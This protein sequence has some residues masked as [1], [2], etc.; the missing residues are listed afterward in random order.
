MPH[1]NIYCNKPTV[2]QRQTDLP[3]AFGPEIMR[4]RCFL[5]S[6]ISKGT[7]F[8][9][10]LASESLQQRCTAIVQSS[11][12]F[13][14]IGG[15]QTIGLY[16]EITFARIKSIS[17]KIR[18]TEGISGID[19]RKT[20]ENSV[21]MRIIS[22]LSSPSEFADAVVCLYHLRWFDKYGFSACRFIVDDTL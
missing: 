11:N 12:L 18:T 9:P 10:C 21:R 13:I 22:R 6:S 5:F 16:G 3:P 14:S 7:T 8:P 17:A 15:F 1:C 19:G 20:L 2:F 4:I